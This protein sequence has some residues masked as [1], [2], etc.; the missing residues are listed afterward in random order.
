VKPLRVVHAISSPAAGG[1]EVYVK[2]LATELAR[3]G[4]RPA[5]LFLSRSADIGRSSAFEEEFLRHLDAI[6]IPYAFLGHEC[7]RN[8]LLGMLRTRRFVH[9][10]RADIYHSHLK[11]SLLFGA[12]LGRPHVHTHHNVLRHAPGWMWPLFNGLVDAWIGISDRCAEQLRTFAGQPVATI[13]NAVDPRRLGAE[14]ARVRCAGGNGV[15]RCIA[16]GAPGEQKN[17]SLLVDAF[18][19][20]PAEVL[21]QV[22]LDIVGEGAPEATSALADRIEAAGLRE[23]IRLV[24]ASN[25]VA[26]M[27]HSADLFLLS[28]AWEGMPI[29][30][31][32]ASMTGLPFIATDVGGC[33]EVARVCGNGVIVPPADATAFAAALSGLLADRGRI[34]ALSRSAIANSGLFSINKSA[35]AHLALYERLLQEPR[36]RSVRRR[37]AE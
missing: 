35:T 24:G 1:A 37:S 15:V 26:G 2:D 17:F 3:E 5:I 34:E 31:L 7:R 20:L 23:T 32:E 18:G 8:P 25:H 10:Q 9:L 33:A 28:S 27:F 13:R 14:P 16:V 12:G 36:R 30:L 29:A 19:L 21:R 6:A 11:Y 4:H 22:R